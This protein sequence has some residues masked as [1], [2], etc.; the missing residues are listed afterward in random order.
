MASLNDLRKEVRA[1]VKAGNDKIRRNADKGIFLERSEY[2]PRMVRD[3]INGMSRRQLNSYKTRL[4]AFT[5]RKVQFVAGADGEPL[6]ADR[7]RLYK[8]LEEYRNKR[9]RQHAEKF[10]DV[11]IPA[12]G[13][14]VNQR[15]ALLE[16]QSYT[17][18]TAGGEDVYRPYNQRTRK[19][20]NIAN[21]K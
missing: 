18:L 16:A 3:N 1:R 5:D 21:A 4:D 15:N 19:I 9:V 17:V 10:G 6:R 12:A 11:H 2:D 8:Q 13:V 20:E 7:V 14:T